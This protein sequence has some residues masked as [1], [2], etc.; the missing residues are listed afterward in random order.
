MVVA[1]T[2]RPGG[3]PAPGVKLHRLEALR[4]LTALYVVVHHLGPQSYHVAGVNVGILL[5]F[6]QEAVLLFFLLSGFVI[7]YSFSRA[8]DRSFRTYFTRRALR[9]YAPLVVVFALSYAVACVEAGALVDPQP[10]VLL[11]NLLMLQDW[12]WAKP[13]VVVEPYMDNGPLWSLSY[14]WWFYMLYWPIMR[15]IGE[16]RSR[17]ALVLGASLVAGA[18][19]TFW[20][21][22]PVRIVAYLGIWWC[23][24]MLADAWA[25]G[26]VRRWAT[27]WPPLGAMGA[28]TAL[29]ALDVA[30]ARA[31]GEDLLFGRHPFHEFR[32]FFFALVALVVAYAWS[33]LSWRGF[34]ALT[35]PFLVVAP[36]SYGLYITHAFLL[37]QASY[38]DVIPV[39]ALE[40]LAYVAVTL[41][42]CWLLELVLYPALRRR[43]LVPSAPRA[44]SASPSGTP[45]DRPS[46]PAR[47]ADSRR[48]SDRPR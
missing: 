17:D 6:G 46:D 12:T 4:G 34:D 48:F 22:M 28:A 24:A 20:P 27:W 14:E 25:A 26:T 11:G 10:E 40:F 30:L 18:V 1:T 31:A 9:I 39:R 45:S 21:A 42:T 32:H 23:G 44:S 43:L 5:R 29:R 2:D 47:R 38:L 41:V 36:I 3:P 7:H 16:R 33:R 35:R 13:N 8:R 15:T 19:Y 37:D